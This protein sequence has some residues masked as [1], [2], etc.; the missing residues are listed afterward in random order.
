MHS[1]RMRTARLLPVSPSMHCGGCLLRGVS[2]PRGCVSARGRCLLSGAGV[3]D[4]G[5]GGV[6]LWSWG[7]VS[8]HVMGQTPY[9]NCGQT[10]TCEKHNL[11]KLRF[12]AV[13][14]NKY[15]GSLLNVKKLIEEPIGVWL[16]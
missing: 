12:R 9:P 5:G 7:D 1:S 6:C 11:R 3:S 10:D 16:V 13:I 2:G 8:Q 15:T 14:I 4:P